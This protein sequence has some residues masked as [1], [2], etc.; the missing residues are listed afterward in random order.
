MKKKLRTLAWG[1]VLSAFIFLP[2]S[3]KK[4]SPPTAFSDTS[5]AE[6][7]GELPGLRQLLA[8]NE[9]SDSIKDALD[10]RH[11]QFYDKGQSGQHWIIVLKKEM[12]Y[13]QTICCRPIRP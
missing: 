7:A 12:W 3:C 8:L 9:L 4:E 2:L 6:A 11:Y 5:Q 13:G 1:A 10:L